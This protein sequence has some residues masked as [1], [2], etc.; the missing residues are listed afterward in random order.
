MC[1]DQPAR[2][3]FVPLVWAD[4]LIKL[5]FSID[6]PF[7]PWYT[8]FGD[9]SGIFSLK[10]ISTST[11]GGLTT[12]SDQISSHFEQHATQRAA[13]F[14]QIRLLEPAVRVGPLSG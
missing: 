13:F 1:N 6:K 14:V 7:Y 2:R 4:Y 8:V 11:V 9:E 5:K 10:L 3:R 12:L